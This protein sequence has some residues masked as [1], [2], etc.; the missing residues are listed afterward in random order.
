MRDTVASVGP[1]SP[2]Y[3]SLYQAV[4]EVNLRRRGQTQIRILCG[5]P[6]IDWKQVKEAKD[7]LPYL[8]S[9]DQ[10]YARIVETDVIAKHHR[11]L[12][13]MGTFHFLR[14]FDMMSTR[15]QFDIEK[16]LRAAGANPY[17][18]VF[19]TNTG[20]KA[21]ELDHC[22][23]SWPIPS[24]VSLADNWMG[25][26]SAIPVVTEGRGPAP[27]SLCHRCP[28][29]VVDGGGRCADNAVSLLH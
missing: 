20:G 2:L 21:G 25:D 5:D 4:R 11:A 28:A 6:N 24:V 22:F 7:I 3:E 16:Q 26:L 12:P 17:L 8:K 29:K 23:D 18:I 9:R 15:K 13:I 19:G 1:P 14:H 10:S 27:T